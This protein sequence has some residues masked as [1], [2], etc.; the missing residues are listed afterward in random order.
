MKSKCELCNRE[1]GFF[2][3]SLKI[4]NTK[5]GI[6]YN[7][8]CSACHRSITLAID[9]I[10]S[11]CLNIVK[12]LNGKYS[13]YRYASNDINVLLFLAVKEIFKQLPDFSDPNNLVVKT[14]YPETNN[15]KTSFDYLIEVTYKVLRNG[16]SSVLGRYGLDVF[17]SFKGYMLK[18][19]MLIEQVLCNC[20]KDGEIIYADIFVSNS[21]L[22][23]FSKKD[24]I[25]RSIFTSRDRTLKYKLI[26][27]GV[28]YDLEIKKQRYNNLKVRPQIMFNREDQR[29]DLVHKIQEYN[30]SK[31]ERIESELRALINNLNI[32]IEK[33][34]RLMHPN[35]ELKN[36]P[37]DS[38]LVSIIKTLFEQD[39]TQDYVKE[40][41]D[42]LLALIVD[43]CYQDNFIRSGMADISEIQDY[44]L[45]AC[46]FVTDFSSAFE[47][48]PSR[49][50]FAFLTPR[51]YMIKQ[52]N[53][54]DFYL[55]T[56]IDYP[57]DLYCNYQYMI[58]QGK[59]EFFIPTATSEKRDDGYFFLTGIRISS[60]TKK[61]LEELEEYFSKN[62]LTYYQSELAYEIDQLDQFKEKEL[63][64]Y[65]RRV[66]VGYGYLPF[67]I[68][69]E[70][71][72]IERRVR[73]SDILMKNIIP[74]REKKTGTNGAKIFYAAKTVNNFE[75]QASNLARD[76]G[77][78][79][80]PVA[81]GLL[82]ETLK[83]EILKAGS[84]E[85]IRLVGD[86]VNETDNLE[87]AFIKYSALTTIEPE[88][89]YYL[90]LFIYYLMNKGLFEQTDFLD[91]YDEAVKNYLKINPGNTKI[92]EFS[93]LNIPNKQSFDT[94]TIK[95]DKVNFDSEK[96]AESNDP[97]ILS[98]RSSSEDVDSVEEL[99]GNY[100]LNNNQ[101]YDDLSREQISDLE[102]LSDLLAQDKKPQ[103]VIT[104]TNDSK[105]FNNIEI[106]DIEDENLNIDNSV[107]E[108]N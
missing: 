67:S 32:T 13:R 89:A 108:E 73:D 74:E 49:P 5:L 18:K 105:L 38:V 35:E 28:T 46:L 82:W 69:D 37:F 7:T 55:D 60:K 50:S 23:F 72:T 43:Q 10:N 39:I 58:F 80:L 84:E 40:A 3:R 25:V 41:P 11:I 76:F 106:I 71:A 26:D 78:K 59:E 34:L 4:E 21:G 31:Q 30:S 22:V 88:K 47:N 52:L 90:G 61:P 57:N 36:I 17:E 91:Y 1:L 19:C 87:S 24:D 9:E 6:A 45:D 15:V 51:A 93:E 104:L 94:Q 85:F 65:A 99:A 42:G 20:G 101:D 77:I 95:I 102:F 100:H 44:I 64:D 96:T 12:A 68:Y 98:I 56:R 63:I 27:I 97:F 86:I 33:D 16:F 103:E 75:H 70:W 62:A 8:L 92:I 2:E 81:R 48:R 66:F 54:D 83:E 29:N 107:I 14:F 79:K 53:H